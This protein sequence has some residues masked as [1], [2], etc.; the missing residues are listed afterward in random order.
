MH[1]LAI[2]RETPAL[3]SQRTPPSVAW[4]QRARLDGR[5][6]RRGGAPLVIQGVTYG[7][8][9][10][11]EYG[12]QIPSM[13]RMRDDF[14]AMRD[15][16]INALRVYHAPPARLLDLADEEG[17]CVLVDVPWRKHLCFLESADARREAR[18][19]M[20]QAAE[21]GRYHASVLG[22]SIGNEIPPDVLRWHGRRPVERFLAELADVVKQVDPDALVTYANFPPTEYLDLS[23]VDFATFNVYLHDREAFRRYL[24]RLQ[25]LV[26]DRPLLLGELGMDTFRNG[27]MAQ[28]LFLNGHIAEGL[29]LC[30]ARVFLFSWTEDWFTGGYRI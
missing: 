4:T 25:N 12:Q 7:P 27:E 16:G 30:L 28:A 20:R 15:C 19:A 8:F 18:Q 3:I 13:A 10:P 21:R 9:A 1:D 2:A 6:F 17:L 24:F 23:F 29:P 14:R 22:Y 5:R 11:D 26:G